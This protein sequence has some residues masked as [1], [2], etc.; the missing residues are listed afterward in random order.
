M[1]K[2][3]VLVVSA[4]VL[5]A[6]VAT[7]GVVTVS[8][9]QAAD[10][11]KPQMAEL[12]TSQKNIQQFCQ[13]TDYRQTCE[14]TLSSV[15]GDNTDP[16]DLVELVFNITIDHI[17]KAFDHSS[18]IQEAAKDP[19]TSEALENC[20]ELLDYAIG[21]LR[22][23]V[24]R[25]EDFSMEKIDKF[26]DD[27]KVWISATITYQETCLDGFEGA[28][29]DAAASMRK[30]L[31]S[32]AEL[33]SNVLAIVTSFGDTLE[34]FELGNLNRKL[35]AVDA[36]SF[37]SWVSGGKRRLLQQSPAELKPDVTVAQD[38][39][40]DVTTIADALLRVPQNSAKIVVM[41]IKEGVY[42][43]KVEIGRSYTNLMMVGDG[44]TKT[45]ITGSLNFIDGVAT[46][47]T[48]TVAVVGDGFIA[49]DLWIENSAGAEKHQA[50]ALRVQ[51]DKSV[52][53]NVRLDGYQD[54]L[55]VHTHRQF[56]REC[57]ITGTIDFIFGD[58]ASIFQNCLILARKPMDNQQNIVTAQGRKDRRSTGGIIL[59]NCTISADPEYYPFRD[60]LPTFLGRPWKEYSRTFVMQ[61]QLDDLINPKGWLPWLGDFGLDTCFYTEIDNR[62]PGADK[63]QRA[64][65]RGVKNVDLIH[66]Q[67]FTVERFIQGKTWLPQTGVPFIAGLLPPSGSTN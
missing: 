4:V 2:A 60:K 41:Y 9:R 5:V 12:S 50:V 57:T 61:S 6:C 35:L 23:S 33:T 38:G 54:T 62:G 20:R 24:D 56:Y 40:G 22:T 16:K 21:D 13:P 39:S 58:S 34:K 7:V 31:N 53:Y 26:I 59:H 64:T 28:D 49:K 37:P 8:N 36:E 65:W 14:T 66:A 52:F 51:S 17:K 25:L 18:T 44:P 55:Y 15:A 10:S 43:E 1:G 30:A 45:K 19:R 3:A 47:K 63:S 29:T 27:L 67:K 46:F 32:S 48:A 42:N 11:S